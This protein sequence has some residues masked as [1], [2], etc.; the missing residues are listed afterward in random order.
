MLE[1]AGQLQIIAATVAF[2]MGIDQPNTRF[3][4]HASPSKSMVC[5]CQLSRT[6]RLDSACSPSCEVT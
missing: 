4:I 3:V 1:H 6:T 2:G 5:L